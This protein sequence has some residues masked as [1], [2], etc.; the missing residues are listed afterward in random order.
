[1]LDS[2]AVRDM[3]LK[4]YGGDPSV[5]WAPGRVNLIG[6]HTDYAGGF[7]MPAAIDFGTLAAVSPRSD[8]QIDIWSENFGD[9]VTVAAGEFPATRSKH[10][11]DY[12]LG[13]VWALRDRG[14]EVPGFSLTLHG[15]VPLG[16]GLSSSA[17]IE[18]A[19][20]LAV[21][22]LAGKEL[23]RDEMAKLCQRA[24]NVYVESPCGIMDQFIACN[25]AE[26]HA[27]LLDCR[28]LEF[29]LAPIP[30]HLSLVIAN[31]MV[32]HSVAGGEYGN[33]RAEV[34][35]GTAILRSHRPEIA[36]LRDATTLDLEKWGH[37][38]PDNVLRRCRH[39]IT[40]NL[41]T[42]AAADALA[43][44]NL[45]RLGDLMAAAHVSYRDDFE[46]SCE[47]ADAMVEAAQRLP[48][49]IGARLTGGGFGGCTVNLVEA[50][51]AKEF[52]ARL[53]DD[54]KA[55]TGIDPDIYRCHASAAAHEV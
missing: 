40:E 51:R 43:E 7:V 5:F 31:T 18:V 14:I 17:S 12:P 6:E 2:N 11:S 33:R 55:A 39:I 38:M 24:E 36:L 27:L 42:V 47:E 37:E 4:K 46:A 9:G 48:G 28:S 25:G 49:L 22:D 44:G 16:A 54:Y 32:K 50:N 23:A 3:H 34:E 1:M 29:R 41:R 52:S 21:L 8:G 30:S 20:A 26:D 10:W 13:V 45:K 35:E 15:D 53:H 19:T